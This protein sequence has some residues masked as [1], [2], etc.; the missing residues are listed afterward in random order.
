MVGED[1]LKRSYY[2]KG[3][4]CQRAVFGVLGS[5]PQVIWL[6]LVTRR[7]NDREQYWYDCK[8]RQQYW[9]DHKLR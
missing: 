8:L 7:T 1:R 2:D 3:D 9:Y 5:N 6:D 4:S